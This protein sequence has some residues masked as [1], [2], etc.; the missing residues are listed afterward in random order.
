M[1]VRSPIL[2]INSTTRQGIPD[3]NMESYEL[4]HFS[5][6]AFLF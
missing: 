6:G 2:S 5:Q 3:Y 1:Y 4:C